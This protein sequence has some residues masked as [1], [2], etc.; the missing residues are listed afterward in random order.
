MSTSSFD[1]Q[2]G[3]YKF[4]YAQYPEIE[5]PFYT[6][7]LEGSLDASQLL[8]ESFYHFLYHQ[9]RLQVD[10]FRDG[11]FYKGFV[12][13][14]QESKLHKLYNDIEFRHFI[15]KYTSLKVQPF[16]AN[17]FHFDRNGSKSYRTCRMIC[18]LPATTDY[19]YAL[20]NARVYLEYGEY[21]PQDTIRFAYT[22][23]Y[24][25]TEFFFYEFPEIG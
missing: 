19:K 10:G 22:K 14:P 8:P 16:N 21:A 5:N 17:D 20:Q 4:T 18:N 9:N 25:R 1:Q 23:N 2:T 24:Y 12:P 6:A 11:R 15:E 3:D 7:F 13:L